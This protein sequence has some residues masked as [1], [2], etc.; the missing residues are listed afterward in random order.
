[1]SA[2]ALRLARRELRTRLT[3]FRIFLICLVLGVGM[4]AAVQS[5]SQGLSESVQHDGRYILGG[6]I[7]VQTTFTPATP[8]DIRELKRIGIVSSVLET[9]A[10]ARN[11]DESEALLTE[12]K[13]VDPF[14]PLYGNVAFTNAKGET[15]VN[16][17]QDYVLP[18][19]AE[20]DATGDDAAYGALVEKEVLERLNAKLG[21]YIFIGTKAFQLRGIIQREPD[22]IGALRFTI[23]PRIMISAGAFPETGLATMGSQLY[24]SHK[25]YMPSLKT[26]QDLQN[27]MNTI[28]A[29]F[30]DRPWRVRSYVNASPQLERTIDRLTVFLTLIGLT[31]L[32]IGGLGIGNAVE[33]HLESKYGT[34][35]TL[36]CLGASRKLIVRTYMTVVLALASLGILLG[37]AFGALA[38]WALGGLLTEKLGLT[39]QIG[40][41]PLQLITAAAFGY[42]ITVCF[43]ILPVAR[44]AGVAPNDLF[45]AAIAPHTGRLKLDYAI[46]VA[47]AAQALALL[48]IVT[49]PDRTLAVQF[50]G[51]VIAA[52]V[53]F[54]GAARLV[55]A[56]ARRLS[57][58]SRAETR[59]ALANI[60]RPGNLAVNVSLSLG[61]GFTVLVT[62]ALV[63]R[64]FDALLRDNL[65]QQTPSFFF[66]DIQSDQMDAFRQDI[67]SIP[68]ARNL[69]LTASYRGRI[70]FVNGVDAETALKDENESW[71]IRSD[72][73]FTYAASQPANST[74]TEGEW[75]P[76]DYSGP[77]A[78]SIATDVARAFDIGVG[79]EL[80]V[81]IMG[82]DFTATVMNV[83]EIDW[84]SFTMNFAVTF[85]P[86]TIDD[87]PGTYIG[88]VEMDEN[89]EVG[90]LRDLAK[91]F[92][93]VT[94]VR[95]R[96]VLTIAAGL[97]RNMALVVQLS[98]AFAIA[99]GILV[100]GGAIAAGRRRKLH[101]AVVLKVLGT[102]RRR[103][104]GIFLIEYGVLGT[105]TA[106]IAALLGTLAAYGI[107]V[108][109]MELKWSFSPLI[110]LATLAAALV[111]TLVLG[112]VGTHRIL[113]QKP[114]SM[115]R[116]Q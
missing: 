67:A 12:V 53:I 116:N 105:A 110:V 52:F 84:G 75:W 98:A 61:L 106:A 4:I 87:I 19:S 91:S 21:D 69:N 109:L 11:A 86:G 45:R 114:A 41:Y 55:Q 38:P 95:V 90:A 71:V 33:S 10:V 108:G 76:A 89:A 93:N 13:A 58:I 18:P 96:D 34:I 22:R 46:I 40:F 112:F 14:Y 70:A 37:L 9:R 107:V 88:T 44:A 99:T 28:K 15:I 83:R 101:D 65:T 54:L 62:V 59:M 50:I 16:K 82:I 66:L 111:I 78:V 85:A 113:G 30:A 102:T 63:E 56:F 68:S 43:S 25:I 47:I 57:T 31:A 77:P 8:Q 7:S 32:V 48:A 26:F 80:T 2:Y 73:G 97:I 79:D 3:G 94:S 92:P 1:M 6:D 64:N 17:I 74:L 72:R 100:L 104:A 23:A 5:L 20:P 35:A 81:N 29:K 42:L 36:K 51:G 39:N 24:Y 103:I 49:S 60:T 27:A 115:L